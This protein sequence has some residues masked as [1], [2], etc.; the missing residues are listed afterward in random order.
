MLYHMVNF[1][2][3]PK[4]QFPKRIDSDLAAILYTS[5]STGNPKG[6]VLTHRNM[7]TGAQSVASYLKNTSDDVLLAVL[8]LSF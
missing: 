3:T 8:P 2:E 7:L 4:A 1:S 6:V 5:G